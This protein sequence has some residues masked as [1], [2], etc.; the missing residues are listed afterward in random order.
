V[1]VEGRPVDTHHALDYRRLEQNSL[2]VWQDNTDEWRAR[3]KAA[4]RC[5]LLYLLRTDP[6]T[7]L[8][9]SIA[10]NGSQITVSFVVDMADSGEALREQ[11]G[12]AVEA[13]QEGLEA[14]RDQ[15]AARGVRSLTS[16]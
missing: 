9:M 8:P 13:L 12:D 15:L 4:I 11:D 3:L 2:A 6:D 14:M 16:E 1:K 10:M 5:Q 7:W